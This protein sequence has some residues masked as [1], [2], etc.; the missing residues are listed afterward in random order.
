MAK[1]SKKQSQATDSTIAL[2]RKARHEYAIEEHLEVGIQ[3]QGWEV[4]SLRAGKAQIADS[5]VIF[6]HSEAFLLGSVIHP[7]IS[8]S[9]HVPAEASRTRKLL[10][11]RK[12]IDRLAGLKERSGYT[13]IPL[14]M[15][16]KG[17]LVK[18]DIGLAKGKKTHDKRQSA[19]D[20]DWKL[21]KARLLK[22]KS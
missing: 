3:L 22:K 12:E 6:K 10:L 5:Y 21:E 19:K 2:N 13:I 20:R 15:Y 14:K 18:L 1:K 4:K 11:H 7:L 17:P 9:T 8:T 16:W